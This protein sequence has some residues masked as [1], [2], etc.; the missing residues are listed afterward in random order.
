MLKRTLEALLSNVR[1][2]MRRR[3]FVLLVTLSYGVLFAP[4]LL[5]L[6]TPESFLLEL[7]PVVTTFLAAVNLAALGLVYVGTTFITAQRLQDMDRSSKAAILTLLP[8]GFL[9]LLWIATQPPVDSGDG[10]NSY[11]RNPRLPQGRGAPRG[12]QDARREFA[13]SGSARD[14]GQ[15]GTEKSTP[16]KPS[17]RE[18]VGRALHRG[19]GRTG[20]EVQRFG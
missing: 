19:D 15:A 20:G 1:G 2:R 5:A 18:H 3:T 10:C 17:P 4:L 16:N 14:A 9:L 12:G 8:G 6:V 7:T 13:G 11:G